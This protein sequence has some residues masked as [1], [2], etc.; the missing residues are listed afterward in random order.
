MVSFSDFYFSADEPALITASADLSHISRV[1]LSPVHKHKHSHSHPQANDPQNPVRN[2][3]SSD[4]LNQTVRLHSH[5]LED[6]VLLG[7]RELYGASYGGVDL[8]YESENEGEERG[9]VGGQEESEPVD[10]GKH[11]CVVVFWHCFCLR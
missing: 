2:S 4:I 9:E 11:S 7:S 1:T 8:A 5:E 10:T 3:T 6:D